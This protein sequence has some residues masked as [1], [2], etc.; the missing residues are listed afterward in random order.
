MTQRL[1]ITCAIDYVNSRPHIGT[2]YE[3][4]GADVMARWHRLR[5][6]EVRLQ[7]GN[8]EHSANVLK[9]AR[10]QG[11]EPLAYCDRMEPAFRQTW[12]RL[13]IAYD[14]FI[15]TTAP[16]HATAV[17]AFFQLI[18]QRQAPD[19]SPNI[20]RGKY[21]GWYCD[22]C[23][24]FYTEKDLDDKKCRVHGL[25]TQWVEEDNYFFA[26]SKYT[27]ALRE[28]FHKH[29]QFILPTIRRNEILRLLDEG[30]QDISVSREGGTWG[31]PLP[32]DARHTVYVWFDALINYLTAIGFGADARQCTTWW[33]QAQVVH[34]I[35]KDITRFHC[36]IWPAMLMAAGLTLPDTVFGHGF[37]YH[38]GE[39]MSKTLGNVVDPLTL[40]EQYGADPLRY[41]VLR[42]NSF[43]RDGDFTWEHFIARYNGDLA[44]GIGNLA[45][46]TIGMVHRYCQGR[47]PARDPKVALVGQEE[48]RALI[49][50]VA[51]RVSA[52]LDLQHDDWDFHEALGAIWA[53]ITAADKFI[54]DNAPWNL[55]KQGDAVAVQ[56]VLAEVTAAVRVITVLLSPFLPTTAEKLW[57]QFG[58]AAVH[59]PLAEQA[60][61]T[62]SGVKQCFPTK[63]TYVV[64][65]PT[66][67]FPR[68]EDEPKEQ[69]MDTTTTTATATPAPPETTAGLIALIAIDEFAKIELRAA[70]I[71]QV[72]RIAGADRLLKLQIDVGDHQRQI[73]A[74]IAQHYT[75][76]ELVGR[77]VCIVANLKPAK[78][79]GIQSEGMLLAASGPDTVSILTPLKP[80]PNGSKIK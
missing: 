19:G 58:Y 8:D 16:A 60:L 17:A 72:E 76:E 79:R 28:H 24:A 69:S 71:L 18:E 57:G 45:S 73:V 52:I 23:E 37:V 47:V 9:A 35:G 25:P 10:A 39:R 68:I 70:T 31:I 29:P 56:A 67:L 61:A 3:K 40:A 4:I 43:G 13:G 36:V 49:G 54:N 64:A 42:E 22:S 30:L 21:T 53:A 75:P 41:F 74:G 77:Q 62:V 20:Y 15:R 12:D 80:V 1:Y 32:S 66:A 48:L 78:L 26:L 27:E 65:E 38:R 34:V 55:H 7:L 33:K 44:N 11:L 63:T 5:G 2:A 59:G 14:G 51:E 46:R 6:W 50:S